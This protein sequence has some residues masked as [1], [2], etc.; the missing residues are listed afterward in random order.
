[1]E[2][3]WNSSLTRYRTIFVD[4]GIKCVD[5]GPVKDCFLTYMMGNWEIMKLS[6]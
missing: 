6:A 4:Y 3:V 2:K 5:P 1:M